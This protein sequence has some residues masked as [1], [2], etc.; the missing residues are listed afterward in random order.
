[1]TA[2]L[3]AGRKELEK[4]EKSAALTAG[5]LADLK[6]EHLVASLADAK[7]FETAGSSAESKVWYSAVD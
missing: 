7:A 2:G 5:R 3:K 1:M 4:A 6:A